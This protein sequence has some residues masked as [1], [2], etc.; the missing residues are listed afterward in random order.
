MSTKGLRLPELA[1]HG[2][3]EKLNADAQKARLRAISNGGGYHLT[4]PAATIVVTLAVAAVATTAA[5]VV[6]A[7]ADAPPPADSNEGDGGGEPTVRGWPSIDHHP[8]VPPLPIYH[9]LLVPSPAT[10]PPS[11]N[12]PPAKR[13]RRPRGMPT[14]L[15]AA[16]AAAATAPIDAATAPIDS[17]LSRAQGRKMKQARA[18]RSTA[19]PTTQGPCPICADENC[20][21][22]CGGGGGGGGDHAGGGGGGDGSEY[23]YE[24]ALPTGH[25]LFPF[26]TPP[27]P[28]TKAATAHA[29]G[30]ILDSYQITH[31]MYE[32]GAI[33]AGH[34]PLNK[35]QFAL[36]MSLLVHI[37]RWV[38]DDLFVLAAVV[39]VAVRCRLAGER[40]GGDLGHRGAWPR[41]V[42]AYLSVAYD[43]A[44]A[45]VNQ[46]KHGMGHFVDHLTQ[47][48]L[49]AAFMT[50]DDPDVPL[51]WGCYSEPHTSTSEAELRR[52]NYKRKFTGSGD[53]DRAGLLFCLQQMA[54]LTRVLM[55]N[56][57]VIR[58]GDVIRHPIERVAPYLVAL[59]CIIE[60]VCWTHNRK[61]IGKFC[62]PNNANGLKK[63]ACSCGP[64]KGKEHTFS[65]SKS[66]KGFWLQSKV[67]MQ[68][69]WLVHRALET[70][71]P[72]VKEGYCRDGNFPES[73]DDAERETRRQHAIEF[74]RV[75]LDIMVEHVTGT[76]GNCAH[77]SEKDG[78]TP[79]N[80]FSCPTQKAALVE[81]VRGLKEKV[82]Q[83]LT[84]RGLQSINYPEANHSAITH[85]R[86][87]GLIYSPASC[88]CGEMLGLIS[89]L[90]LQMAA[91]GY[92]YYPKLMLQNYIHE[93]L[94]VHYAVDQAAEVAKLKKRVHRKEYRN[95]PAR[96]AQ[97]AAARGRVRSSKGKKK[98]ESYVGGGTVDS[99]VP[100]EEGPGVQQEPG[101]EQ[102]EVLPTA[103]TTAATEAWVERLVAGEAEL[104]EQLGDW[105]LHLS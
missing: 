74:V 10:P 20:G 98:D 73:V 89:Q 65:H 19:Q 4:H 97:A 55:T 66:K 57:E 103:S 68:F 50:K 70:Y 34:R 84:R 80:Q 17:P 102:P 35:K 79:T 14:P 33:A 31:A 45:C 69:D 8:P 1:A 62:N 25:P 6:G 94:G 30:A 71:L 11:Q 24:K 37:I 93:H 3:T 49:Q 26:D 51:P 53:M 16:I 95:E 18:L 23:P 54:A 76:H 2:V 63:A 104:E 7:V 9:H 78:W 101:R 92:F 96:R 29:L 82:P 38:L 83:I 48:P 58:D 60:V 41:Y 46:S 32:P 100:A 90:Q 86:K 27:F 72:E 87:K 88:F 43:G 42:G 91:W 15:L 61:N 56:L 13:T 81:Y 75:G 105:L 40:N 22:G 47:I 59:Y 5:L 64:G 85:F 52:Q 39:V 12:S 21:G 99:V 44:W 28:V 67:E 36:L 77:A